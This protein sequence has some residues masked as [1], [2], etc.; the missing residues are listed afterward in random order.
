MTTKAEARTVKNGE[1]WSGGH[2]SEWEACK[3]LGAKKEND[4]A[5]RPNPLD[6][7]RRKGGSKTGTV[8]KA[9][10]SVPIN[11]RATRTIRDDRSSASI[12][13]DMMFTTQ[14]ANR[15]T[16]TSCM[17]KCQHLGSLK[18][19]PFLGRPIANGPYPQ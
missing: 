5:S 12:P 15:H 8:K 16:V 6:F 2:P 11:L 3:Q 1:K 9:Q 18:L 7:Y 4:G 13:M 10:D 19:G 17:V 14:K